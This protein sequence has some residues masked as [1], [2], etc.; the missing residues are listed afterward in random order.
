MV[1]GVGGKTIY[2]STII[3]KAWNIGDLTVCRN[4]KGEGAR[5]DGFNIITVRL[6]PAKPV[7]CPELC[8][9][10]FKTSLLNAQVC[11]SESLFISSYCFKNIN[12]YL[13]NHLL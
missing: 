4:Q 10:D 7:I 13:L 1:L 9:S 11:S 6:V 2:S 8:W 5:N 3:M 12:P